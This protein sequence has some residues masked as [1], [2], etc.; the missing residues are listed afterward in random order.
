MKN[1]LIVVTSHNTLIN[2]ESKTGLWIGEFTDP[3]YEFIDKGHIVTIASPMGGQ[4]PIDPISKLT[5]H[6]TESNRRFNEDEA[7]QK[8]LATTELLENMH[9]SVFD[10]VF[11][12]GGHGPMFDLANDIICANLIVD[13]YKQKKLI[14]AVCHGPAALTKAASIVPE[15]LE[16]KKVTGY[17]NAEEALVFKSNNIPF[18]LEDRLKKLGAHYTS[19]LIPFTSH[20]EVD[21]LLITGQNPLS[22]H[23]TAQALTDFWE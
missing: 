12:P 19:A 9:A 13:F 11:F 8:A 21:G 1:I 3:Y 7:A 16:G 4:P 23:A 20:V 6:I 5:E 22:S 2:T 18:K 17:S 14:G 10:A 15:L